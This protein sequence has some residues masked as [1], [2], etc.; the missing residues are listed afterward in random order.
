MKSSSRL[1]I[2]A[3]ELNI[4]EVGRCREA[5]IVVLGGE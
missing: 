5:Y 3:S 2:L 4:A 1:A